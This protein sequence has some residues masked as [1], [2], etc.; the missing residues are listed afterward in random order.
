M[1]L[2]NKL[3]QI[4]R[5]GAHTSAG[6]ST[7]VFSKQDLELIAAGYS[8]K[9]LRAPLVLGHPADNLPEYGEVDD[10]FAKGDELYAQATVG[11]KLLEMVRTGRYKKVSLS[12]IAPTSPGNPTPGAYY[13]R[14]VGFLGSQPPAVKGMAAP[15]FAEAS[16]SLDFSEGCEILAAISAPALPVVAPGY[17]LSKEG[18]QIF[19]L[20]TDYQR[21]C[22]SLSFVEAAQRAESILNT[23]L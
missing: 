22:P 20:A 21:A 17:R 1:S 19:M 4:F 7:L 6:G 5:T 11:D 14:H 13:L 9:R 10:L 23:H 18:T 15:S 12:L 8:K 16:G 3:F 2:Q